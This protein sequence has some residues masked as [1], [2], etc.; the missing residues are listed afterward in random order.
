MALIGSITGESIDATEAF[1]LRLVQ[2]VVPAKQLMEEALRIAEA[3]CR[4]GRNAVPMIKEVAT[5]G[6]NLPI[7]EALWLEQV[8]F[9]RNRDEAIGEI[10]ERLRAFQSRGK[11]DKK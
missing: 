1:R 7:A 4:G 5:K 10:E 2:K 8:Y 3:V 9:K 11:K 6:L